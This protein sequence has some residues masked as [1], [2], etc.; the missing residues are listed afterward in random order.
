LILVAEKVTI[1][2]FTSAVEPFGGRVI[3]TNLDDKDVA[4]LRKALRK[5]D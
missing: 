2:D 5:T 1:A 3:E 4:A